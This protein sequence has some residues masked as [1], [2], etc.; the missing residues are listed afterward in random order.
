MFLPLQTIDSNYEVLIAKLLAQDSLA[1]LPLGYDSSLK[2]GYAAQKK[3]L[4][5]SYASISSA[6]L[7]VFFN[8]DPTVVTV[9]Q[10]PMSRGSVYINISDPFG[11]PV[12]DPRVF[13]NPVDMEIAVSMFKYTRKWFQTPSQA[14]LSPFEILPGSSVTSDEESKLL[15]DSFLRQASVML[16]GRVL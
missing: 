4:L 14:S 13:S 6:M 16:W 7:E 2:Q 1:Y 9:L 3:L 10:K 5:D 8:G 12:I 11:D 15:Y